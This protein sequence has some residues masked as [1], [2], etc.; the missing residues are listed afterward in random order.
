MAEE[1]KLNWKQILVCGLISFA[2]I[3]MLFFFLVRSLGQENYDRLIG[4]FDERFGLPGLFLY[5][6]LVDFLV[7][8]VSVD[9]AFPIAVAYPW[10]QA[11]PIMGVASAL[12]GLTSYF[13]G[14]LILLIPFVKKQVKKVDEKWG[15]YIRRYGIWFVIVSAVMPLPFSTIC[16]AAG[17]VKLPTAQVAPASLLRIVRMGLYFA[18]FSA[19]LIFA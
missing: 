2:A 15:D 16:I 19:G 12:G 7:L 11:V 18:L 17:I 9:L 10:Y 1:K 14:R 6:Y 13:L 3:F 4:Y 5:V 8:P